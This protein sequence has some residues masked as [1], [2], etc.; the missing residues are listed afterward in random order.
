MLRKWLKLNKSGSGE[1]PQNGL[2]VVIP[3]IVGLSDELFNLLFA[4]HIDFIVKNELEEKFVAATE[5]LLGN[6]FFHQKGKKVSFY[7][8]FAL[9]CS[10]L[11]IKEESNKFFPCVKGGQ[12]PEISMV[13]TFLSIVSEDKAGYEWV[14]SSPELMAEVWKF[15]RNSSGKFKGLV[16]AVLH[17]ERG[18][19]S[20][21][22]SEENEEFFDA[23]DESDITS[24]FDEIEPADSID[25]LLNEISDSNGDVD[26]TGEKLTTEISTGSVEITESS[27]VDESVSSSVDESVS[28][29]DDEDVAVDISKML[30]N[31]NS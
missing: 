20:D 9:V 19:E 5:D 12:I 13:A 4:P 16:Y 14:M 15:L 10:A 21:E 31:G 25:S 3:N 17:A 6:G 28:S 22:H 1:T 23:A 27:G 7:L 30:T 11:A 2:L 18:F 24:M 8:F 29:S 26:S